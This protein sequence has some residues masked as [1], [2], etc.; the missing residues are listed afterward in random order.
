MHNGA[1]LRTDDGLYVTLC[2]LVV[3]KVQHKALHLLAVFK[4]EAVEVSDEWHK[5]LGIGLDYLQKLG[6]QVSGI[7]KFRVG[8]IHHVECSR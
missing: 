6:R 8:P 3:Q 2:A 5:V 7:L 1:H 4:V